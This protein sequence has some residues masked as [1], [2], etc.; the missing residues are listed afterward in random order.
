[1]WM[2]PTRSLVYGKGDP[3]TDVDISFPKPISDGIVID[4]VT[5]VLYLTD[6]EH[7]A[8]WMTD[9]TVRIRICFFVFICDDSLFILKTGPRKSED[10]R[11][12]YWIIEMAGWV[13]RIT[14][15]PVDNLFCSSRTL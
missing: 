2:V 3:E 11:D 14:R 7:S 9:P 12:K 1:M 4:E 15:I 5:G 6:F 8:I 13:I 10:S